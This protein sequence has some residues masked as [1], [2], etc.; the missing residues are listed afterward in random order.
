M[1]K[2]NYYELFRLYPPIDS[3]Q[4]QEVYR[5]LI[6][7][8]HPDRNPDRLDWA[9]EHTM[10]IVDA[11]NVLSD[12]G[13]R[14]AYNFQI[15]NDI[16]KEPG[17]NVGIK[18]GF[19]KIGRTKD[20]LEGVALFLKGVE[21]FD[22][23]DLWNQAQHEWNQALKYLPGLTNAYFNLGILFGYQGNFKDSMAA[24]NQA[25]K[26]VPGDTETKKAQSM[27]MGYVYGK[28]VE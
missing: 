1:L 16:R 7:E 4:L 8:F 28:R 9:V 21:C 15:R 14:D 5:Q 12:P 2:K 25:L 10:E 18:K 19:L 26:L 22:D 27:A 6:F 23:K 13:K 24:L 17:E 20:E 11:Y 3:N